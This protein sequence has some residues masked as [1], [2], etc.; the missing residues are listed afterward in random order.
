MVFKGCVS[1]PFYIVN[2]NGILPIEYSA[3]EA[4]CADCEGGESVFL[5]NDMETL[6]ESLDDQDQGQS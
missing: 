5:A 2:A 3:Y 6:E 1:M 4:A